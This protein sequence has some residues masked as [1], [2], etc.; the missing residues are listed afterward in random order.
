VIR[1]AKLRRP[2]VS[3]KSGGWLD[4]FIFCHDSKK[5]CPSRRGKKKSTN[6]VIVVDKNLSQA[7][8]NFLK[9]SNKN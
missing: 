3:E 7:L 1:D 9:A 4:F 6:L 2:G 5:M 8:G